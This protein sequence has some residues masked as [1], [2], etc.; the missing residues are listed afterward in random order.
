MH[1][2]QRHFFT[3]ALPHPWSVPN[4]E[5]SA[6]RRPNSVITTTVVVAGLRPA[7][8]A[9]AGINVE[10]VAP[11]FAHHREDM[12]VAVNRAQQRDAPQHRRKRIG[13]CVVLLVRRGARHGGDIGTATH[14]TEMRRIFLRGIRPRA[15]ERAGALWDGRPCCRGRTALP[16][17]TPRGLRG[18]NG[19]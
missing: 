19:A 16:T 11:K 10:V 9:R 14:R 1:I 5:F 2:A 7:A 3:F 17:P 15:R 4:A 18:A 8:N 6:T 12:A 13:I